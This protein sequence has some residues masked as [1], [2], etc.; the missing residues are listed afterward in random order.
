[1]EQS[2][3]VSQRSAFTASPAPPPESLRN[4]SQQIATVI[5]GSE[6]QLVTL[7]QV[8]DIASLELTPC[9]GYIVVF[10]K[11]VSQ[12]TIDRQADEVNANGGS[13]KHKYYSI[14]MK[15]RT[16]SPSRLVRTSCLTSLTMCNQG[17]S[18]EI[19]EVYLLA[20]QSNLLQPDS[21]IA[22]IGKAAAI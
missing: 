8:H 3:T 7:L 12:D 15:V 2:Y 16:T 13:V 22:Y 17:F 6:L 20:L 18:A 14:I 1:M 4:T 19:P 21:P 11:D 5:H 10:E 9:E